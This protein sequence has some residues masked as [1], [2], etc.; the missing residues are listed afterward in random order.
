MSYDPLWRL[1]RGQ[2]GWRKMKEPESAID[3]KMYEFGRMIDAVEETWAD[4]EALS[5]D[6]HRNHAERARAKN[7]LARNQLENAIRVLVTLALSS[8]NQNIEAS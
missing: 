6:G 7:T 2:K 4:C 5:D 8:Q 3:V 1:A